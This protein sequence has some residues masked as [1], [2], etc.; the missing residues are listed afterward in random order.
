[1]HHLIFHTEEIPQLAP[2]GA[3]YVVVAVCGEWR[4]GD[5]TND[6]SQIPHVQRQLR[7]RFMTRFERMN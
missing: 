2:S 1:M 6:A 3:R 5:V 7:K 4:D